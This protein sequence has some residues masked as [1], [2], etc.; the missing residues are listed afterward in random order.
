MT[1]MRKGQLV[2][3]LVFI[4]AL[5]SSASKA[6]LLY[7]EALDGDA[8]NTF[9]GD[10]PV[11]NLSAGDNVIRG[12]GDWLDGANPDQDYYKLA[13]SE[14]EILRSVTLGYSLN[15]GTSSNNWSLFEN[16]TLNGVGW[17]SVYTGNSGL[18]S[19]SFQHLPL[20]RSPYDYTFGLNG[21][22]KKNGTDAFLSYEI[23]FSVESTVVP[24]P[25]T[26][27]LFLSGI[28]G[29]GFSTK[30]KLYINQHSKHCT[31]VRRPGI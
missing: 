10:K 25:P 6:A 7:D 19:M 28:I 15:G 27:I 29:L 1:S 17:Q 22:S 23:T 21:W 30:R 18:L 3:G 13:I 24:L 14:N 11:I 20:S 12:S 26:A 4:S 9:S 16:T 5:Y 2:L 8:V 31:E